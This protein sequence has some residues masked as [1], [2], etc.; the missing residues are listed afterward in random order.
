[1]SQLHTQIILIMT[2]CLQ[3]AVLTLGQEIIHCSCK[4]MCRIP[5]LGSL[6]LVGFLT[7][8]TNRNP[9]QNRP[10][11]VTSIPTIMAIRSED[12]LQPIVSKFS[13][14]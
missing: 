4:A 14:S 7:C 3:I 8:S 6:S 13:K 5:V 10:P 9:M 11:R 1:M 2:R 12:P